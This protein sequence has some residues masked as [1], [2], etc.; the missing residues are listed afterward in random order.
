MPRKTDT[1]SLTR[2][3]LRSPME[4]RFGHDRGYKI[5]LHVLVGFLSCLLLSG[6]AFGSPQAPKSS[7][8]RPAAPSVAGTVAV[9]ASQGQANALAGVEVRLRSQA[10]GSVS[11]S[12]V[13]G[14]DG[15]YQFT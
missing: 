1:T 12:T 6:V 13:T 3:C 2:S 5:T 11:Q 10:P 7:D 4:S 8:A 9:I 14:E 15:R